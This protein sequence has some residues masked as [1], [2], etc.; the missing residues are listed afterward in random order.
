MITNKDIAKLASILV[1]KDDLSETNARIDRVE[2]S[3]DALTTIVDNLAKI[4]ID[5]RND[6]KMLVNLYDRHDRWIKQL[7]KETKVNLNTDI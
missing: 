2:V 4:T 3:I 7:A 5:I 6:H 1:T